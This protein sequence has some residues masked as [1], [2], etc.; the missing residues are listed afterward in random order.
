MLYGSDDLHLGIFLLQCQ[1]IVG[2]SCIRNC[3]CL[4]RCERELLGGEVAAFCFGLQ[5]C[6]DGI[7]TFVEHYAAVLAWLQAWRAQLLFARSQEMTN[8]NALEELEQIQENIL[9]DLRNWLN[10]LLDRLREC[11]GSTSS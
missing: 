8:L 4:T 6:H 7:Q 11:H 10:T 2:A 1:Q 9:A 3:C 5:R